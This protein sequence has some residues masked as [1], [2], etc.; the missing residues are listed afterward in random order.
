MTGD[1]YLLVDYGQ[2][3]SVELGLKAVLLKT[4]ITETKVA[5]VVDMIPSNTS[6]LIGYDNDI[7]NG[8]KLKDAIL[9]L[10][11]QIERL[12]NIVVP[13][14]LIEFPILFDDPWTRESVDDYCK[15]IKQIPN[16]IE[17]ILAENRLEDLNELITYYTT[18]VFIV[19]YVGFWPGLA[20]FVCTDPR[21]VISVPKYNP[22][23]TRT[24]TGAIGIGGVNTSIYPM[25]TPGGFQLF[26]ILPTPIYH[27]EQKLPDFKDAAV[28]C[29]T[30]DRLTFRAVDMDEYQEIK[31]ECDAGTYRFR[32]EE[33]S[34]FDVN[35]YKQFVASV[36]K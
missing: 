24:P 35:E 14:R 4:L 6:L 25:D 22:P 18:P 11:L 32:I 10:M 33:D 17:T 7:T 1:D 34:T 21:Y 27:P 12:D 23:R 13:S 19:T 30:T 3:S 16:N 36:S 2:V 5:G 8:H 28:L 31:R 26:G 15:T 20:S 9:E 29:R